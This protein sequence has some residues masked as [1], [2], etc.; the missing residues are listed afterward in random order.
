MILEALKESHRLHHRDRP[1]HL[2]AA[3]FMEDRRDGWRPR[4]PNPWRTY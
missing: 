2:V 1:A 3:F 4:H